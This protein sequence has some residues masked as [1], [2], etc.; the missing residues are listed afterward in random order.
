M[1][2]PF[3][4]CCIDFSHGAAE[5]FGPRCLAGDLKR[6]RDGRNGVGLGDD[7]QEGE[8]HGG[9]GS[10]GPTPR[11]A[12]QRPRGHAVVPSRPI[13]WG[14][15][16]LPERAVRR[17]ADGQVPGSSVTG[18]VDSCRPKREPRRSSRASPKSRIPFLSGDIIVAA[19]PSVSGAWA[20]AAT[21]RVS[22]TASWT[23]CMPAKDVPQTM[24]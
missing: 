20:T 3:C 10:H 9:G 24:I 6:G 17:G 1:A 11:E 5:Q 21:S 7:E 16:F 14:H 2:L 23:M 12:E 13:L 4:S 22:E 19:K 18:D 8:T 15:K